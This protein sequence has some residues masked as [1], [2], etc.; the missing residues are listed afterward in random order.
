VFHCHNRLLQPS[1][2]ALTGQALELASAHVI[3]CCQN[4][5]EPLR[6]YVAPNRLHILYNGVA[7]MAAGGLRFPDRIRKIGVVGRI[8]VEKGQLEFVRAARL[9]FEKAPECYFTVIGSPMFSGFEYYRKVVASSHGLPIDFIDWGSDMRKLYSDL[10]LLVVPSG[11]PEATTRVILEAYSA[12]IPVVAFPVGGIPEILEDGQTGFLAEDVTAEALANRILSIVRM[13]RRSVRAVVKRARKEWNR[14]FTLQA[15]RE[16]VCG[17]LA[18]AMQPS[19]HSHY[20]DLRNA[21]GVL[22]D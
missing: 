22:T 21:T 19:V 17:V 4:A 10:D 6:E 8:E 11:A 7:D 20:A 15:Y 18:Q 14:R 9:V 16:S 12:G 3:A 13:N 5:A 1:A 2:I